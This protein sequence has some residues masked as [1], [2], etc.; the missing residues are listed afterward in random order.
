MKNPRSSVL[1]R[2]LGLLALS[3]LALVVASVLP[4]GLAEVASAAG[5]PAFR[6]SETITRSHLNADGSQTTVDTASIDVSVSQIQDLRGRQQIEVEWSGAHPTGGIVADP[7]SRAAS[8][9][10]YPVVI[11]E[12]RGVDAAGATAS[13]RLTP[14]TCWTQTPDER[15]QQDYNNAFPAWRV[16]RYAQIDDRKATVGAP[17]TNPCVGD[18]LVA[19]YVPFV[20]TDGTTYYGGSNGCAGIPP[21]GVTVQD[22]AA[23]PGNTTYAAT[24]TDGTG[25]ATFVVWTAQQ[26]ASLGCSNTVACALVIVPIMGVSCDITAAAMPEQDRPAAGDEAVA[27]QSACAATGRYQPGELFSSDVN[28]AYGDTTVTGA[29]WWSAS[30]WRNRITVPL[31]FAPPANVCDILDSRTPVDL[32]GSELMSQATVQ[33][34]AAFCQDPRRFKFRHVRTGEPQAKSALAAGSVSAALISRPPPTGY[35]TTTVNAPVAVT[36]FAISFAVDD[37]NKHEY[38]QLKLTPRLLAKLLSESYYSFQTLRTDYAALP[39]SDPYAAMATNPQDLSVDPEFVALNPGIGKTVQTQAAATLLALSGDSD[40]MFALTSYLNAD[41]EAR[42]F[43]DG[44]PDPWG[45]VVNPSY[46]GIALPLEYWPLLD[47]FLASNIDLDGCLRNETQEIVPVPLL[48]L[49]AAPMSNLTAISQSM[50]YALAN[51]ATNCVPRL[52]TGGQVVGG[53]LKAL[54]RQQPGYR[55][56]LGLTSLADTSLLG[57][58]TAAL[59]S[60]SSIKDLSARFTNAANRHFVTPTQD[61]LRAAME[62]TTVDAQSHTWPIPYAKLRTSAGATAYPGTMVVYAAVPTTGLDKTVAANLAQLLRFAASDGQEPGLGQG[63]LPDGYLPMTAANGLAAM[64]AYTGYAAD[65]V[66]AQQGDDPPVTGPV[67]SPTPIVTSGGSGQSAG[68]T[69]APTV[70]TSPTPELSPWTPAVQLPIGYTRAARSATA[71]WALP[72]VVLIGL[73]AVIAAVVTPA[74]ATMRMAAVIRRRLRTLAEMR[75]RR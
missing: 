8:R 11:L 69:S 47:N 7:N 38:G 65:A 52:T 35:A 43:L 56:M 18:P 48:P 30:N 12:C 10:E 73:L 20:A 16:D 46:K 39:A 29:L 9:Q 14:Q 45:M 22:P 55:F 68:A 34:S 75:S 40:T 62:L 26:N 23:P 36:G 64:V 27:A 50:Q 25:S 61:S 74:Q 13:Q 31:T 54:G 19:R 2:R 24:G 59:Q 60:D 66:Q 32:Y 63:Q 41:P 17:S 28:K 53:T 51:S 5:T 58:H 42:A 49:V 37:A 33:W 21:E 71:G 15:Y 44:K 70:A 3:L 57:L 67:A 6:T 72:G 1:A 4:S